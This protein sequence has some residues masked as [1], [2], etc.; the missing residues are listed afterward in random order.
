M[1]LVVNIPLPP[2]RPLDQVKAFATVTVPLPVRVPP[3]KA[4]PPFI[5]VVLSRVNVPLERVS[6]LAKVETPDTVR[7]P[8]ETVK[9]SV[10]DI[11]L[12]LN[13]PD[14]IVMVGVPTTSSR[15]LSV[16]TGRV[17]VFQLSALPQVVPSPPPSHSNQ[18]VP[19]TASDR[20]PAL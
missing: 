4:K 15:T 9:A 1:P 14:G 2:I 17:S 6:K 12:T 5:A 16:P 7:L 19:V 10:L 11:R 13:E 8:P 18:E 3:L 20:L